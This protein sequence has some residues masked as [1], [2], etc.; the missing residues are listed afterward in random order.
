MTIDNGYNHALF[1]SKSRVGYPRRTSF[2][3]RGISFDRFIQE[4]LINMVDSLL[5]HL[6]AK[7]TEISAL[8]NNIAVLV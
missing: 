5:L 6:F 8:R 7:K 1:S 4:R 3:Q 2:G